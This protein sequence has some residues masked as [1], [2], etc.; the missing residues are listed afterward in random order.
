MIVLQ[1]VLVDI[2]GTIIDSQ[3]RKDQ[4]YSIVINELNKSLGDNFSFSLP[5][6]LKKRDLLFHFYPDGRRNDPKLLLEEFLH[7]Y[8]INKD[9]LKNIITHLL[10]L[11]WL[12]LKKSKPFK[13]ASRFLYEIM[14]NGFRYILYSDGT[15]EETDFKL[16]LLPDS[17]LPKP[18]LAIVSDSRKCSNENIIPL[19][20]NKNVETYR[21]LK[22]T[23]NVIAMVGDSENFDILPAKQAGLYCF[24][25]IKMNLKEILFKLLTIKD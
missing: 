20:R 12:N 10:N 5:E 22:K 9:E 21:F 13:E 6:L 17:F 14:R 8:K 19:G 11:Y 23:Y 16:N 3:K 7:P 2:D 4:F 25:V 24:N 18:Y 15:S 1:T